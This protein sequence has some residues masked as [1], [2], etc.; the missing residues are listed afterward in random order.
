MQNV[1]IS[2]KPTLAQCNEIRE[3]LI[4]EEK[5]APLSGF[6]CNWNSIQYS[7]D[8]GKMAVITLEKGTIGFVTWFNN[9]RVTK[10]QIA[11]IKPGFRKMGYGRLLTNALL[12]HLKEQGVIAVRLHCQPSKSEVAWRKLGF[13]RFP[14]VP[15]MSALNNYEEGRNLYQILVPHTKLSKSKIPKESI[16]LWAVEAYQAD[17]YA[18]QWKWLPKFVM[19]SRKLVSPI[20]APAKYKWNIRWKINDQIIKDGQ[21][22]YFGNTG[23]SYDTFII[24]EELPL[25]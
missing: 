22:K 20:I 6:Y 23:I 24:I 17:R 3:W 10:I 13:K 7:F 14:N 12:A 11:E 8:D 5:K 4:A 18:S 15:E 21:V 9:D 19:G 25:P 2:F 16:E 1:R